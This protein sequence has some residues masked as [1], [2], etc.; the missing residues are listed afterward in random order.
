MSDKTI[1]IPASFYHPLWFSSMKITYE[2]TLGVHEL[3]EIPFLLDILS[4]KRD[5][6]L[7]EFDRAGYI[8]RFFERWKVEKEHIAKAFSQRSRRAARPKMIVGIGW[9]ITLVFWVNGKKVER[10]THLKDDLSLFPIQPVNMNE[11]LSFIT[12]NPDHYQ[13]FIQLA[14]LF[15]E[16]EKKWVMPVH[17]EQHMDKK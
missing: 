12:E 8:H 14:Q 7:Y 10:L 6:P 16:L 2:D 9:L 1:Q 13:S 3:A 4:K 5:S 15:C 17:K 11:R